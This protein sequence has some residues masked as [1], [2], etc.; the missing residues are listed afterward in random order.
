MIAVFPLGD[1]QWRERCTSVVFSIHGGTKGWSAIYAVA[2]EGRPG[3]YM[4]FRDYSRAVGIVQ[5]RSQVS[6]R[7]RTKSFIWL[8][9]ASSGD[10]VS[11]ASISICYIYNSC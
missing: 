6:L 3:H 9:E 10:S 2:R 4:I 8:P 7:W 11:K 5:H 1:V